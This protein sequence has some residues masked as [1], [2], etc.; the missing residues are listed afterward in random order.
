MPLN[1]AYARTIH[2]FQ[3][4]SAGPV[5][6]NRIPNMYSCVICDPGP[7]SFEARHPGLLYTA[8]SRGTTLGDELGSDSAVYFTGPHMLDFARIKGI[9]LQDNGQEYDVIKYRQKWTQRL[10]TNTTK[11][12][13]SPKE[14]QILFEWSKS[15]TTSILTLHK[16]I[17]QYIK[18]I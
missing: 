8:V 17:E 6:N 1:V 16:H 5:D 14:Q 10:K 2:R 18:H 11:S 13:L 4:L 15:N 3:G 12:N 7:R 9:T